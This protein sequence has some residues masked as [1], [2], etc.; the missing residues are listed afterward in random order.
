MGITH[1]KIPIPNPAMIRA[2]MNMATLTDPAQ[3]AAPT[4]KIAAP[5]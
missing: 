4:T 5:V 2:T 3:S 1:V